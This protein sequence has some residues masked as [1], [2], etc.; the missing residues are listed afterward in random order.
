[1]I[2]KADSIKFEKVR[3][4]YEIAMSNFKSNTIRQ[5]E[6][7]RDLSQKRLDKSN[8]MINIS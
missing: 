4:N 6:T 2:E 8:S 3:D 7:T 1:M 5:S